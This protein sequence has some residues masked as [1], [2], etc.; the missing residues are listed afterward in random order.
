MHLPCTHRNVLGHSEDVAALLRKIPQIDLVELDPAHRCC[1]AAGTYFVT[2]PEMADRLLEPKLRN[3]ALLKAD[4][5][6]S[7]NIGC[8]LHLAGGLRR[9]G[10]QQPEVL[11]PA[12][13]L[14]RQLG[15]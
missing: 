2:E 6:V 12:T 3:A 10:L 15:D 13:L 4:Y 7:T 5:I 8:S 14:A 1:G 9:R 11:H